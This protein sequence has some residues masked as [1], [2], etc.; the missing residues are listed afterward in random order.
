V[1]RFGTIDGLRKV[2]RQGGTRYEAMIL[3]KLT[4]LGFVD[5]Y[6]A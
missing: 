2:P 6:A 4:Y 3:R 1:K 5:F